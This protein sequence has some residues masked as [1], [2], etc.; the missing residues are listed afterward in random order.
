MKTIYKYILPIVNEFELLLPKDNVII[1]L[2]SQN[3]LPCLWAIVDPNE[4]EIVQRTFSCFKTGEPIPNIEGKVRAFI[5]TIKLHQE[6]FIVH[7]FENIEKPK[8][9]IDFMQEMMLA[10]NEAKLND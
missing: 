6:T 9:F 7:F 8:N 3:N 5:K 2:D 4:K 1:S 10:T